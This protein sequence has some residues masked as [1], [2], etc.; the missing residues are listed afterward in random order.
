MIEAIRAVDTNHALLVEV[1]GRGHVFFGIEDNSV[2]LETHNHSPALYTK[3]SK[4]FSN[5]GPR[6]KV[7]HDPELPIPP[8]T[9]EWRQHILCVELYWP[10]WLVIF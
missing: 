1:G 5:Q 2:L 8:E 3:Q 9:F 7:Y 10:C 6:G 4:N